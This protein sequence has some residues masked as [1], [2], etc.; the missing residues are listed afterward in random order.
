M[1]D[2]KNNGKIQAYRLFYFKVWCV[3]INSLFEWMIDSKINEGLSLV[4]I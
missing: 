4:S 2:K 1:L 3:Q